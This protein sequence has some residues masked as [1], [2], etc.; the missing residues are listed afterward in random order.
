[1]L[2]ATCCTFRTCLIL[3]AVCV[4]LPRWI[5][6]QLPRVRLRADAL[7]VDL[8]DTQRAQLVAA[9]DLH[10]RGAVEHSTHL[11]E[12]QFPTSRLLRSDFNS[13]TSMQH[14]PPLA[15]PLHDKLE[16]AQIAR[17]RAKYPDIVIGYRSTQ[18]TPYP[19]HCHPISAHSQIANRTCEW[20]AR[21][22]RFDPLASAW[23]AYSGGC[24]TGG[25]GT[26]GR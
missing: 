9:R 26:L 24:E 22:A 14:A 2:S 6:V 23:P 5:Y 1:M 20:H 8:P 19:I 17:M 10:Y 13:E 11:N 18:C 7:R 12:T 3:P 16:L 25:L 4:V 21:A 15:P